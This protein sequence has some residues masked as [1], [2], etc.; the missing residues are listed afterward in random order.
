[1]PRNKLKGVV[2]QP[3]TYHHF[4]RG[5]NQIADVVRPTLGP[6]ARTVANASNYNRTELLDQGGVIA[7]R[8]IELPDG[9]EDMGAMYLRHLLWRLHEEQ[10]DGT[11]TAAVL[12]QSIYNQGVRYIA[13]GGNAMRLRTHLE[14][15]LR[16]VRET[17]Q[18][19]TVPVQ[20]QDAL[21]G[22]A[23]TISHDPELAGML[24]EI[25]DI[26]GEHG[27]LDIRNGRS[28]GLE[29]EYVEGS[30]WH[31]GIVSREMYAEQGKKSIEF[32][33]TAIF[34]SDLEFEEPE[35][36]APP[37]R[38]AMGAGKR[39][40][41]LLGSKFS[42]RVIGF[43]LTNSKP[44]KFRIL[45]VESPGLQA[46]DR[47]AAMQDMALLTG[48]TPFFKAT[49]Q[50]IAQVQPEHLGMARVAWANRFNVGV[51][52]GKGDPKQLRRHIRQLQQGF[53][54]A[55][56]P[57]IR[58]QLQK[59]L[60]KLMGGSATLRVGAVTKEEMDARKRLAET[61]ANALRGAV[62]TGIVPGGGV[63]FLHCAQALR[64]ALVHIPTDQDEKRAAYRILIQAMEQP[65]RVM[66]ENGGHD[67]GSVMA[68]IQTT[69][70][71]SG[72]DLRTDQ[73]V[74]VIEAGI[75]DVASVVDA[76]V[77]GAVS[78]AALA[79]TVDVLVHVK[80]PHRKLDT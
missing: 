7:R 14:D 29:R 11:A 18:A 46:D 37:V 72:F 19:L 53:T 20:G 77:S 67:P 52:G 21:A 38:A 56:N 80:V 55:N 34:I 9:N 40:L 10:G 30:Y 78:S 36:V 23:E 48:G 75:V 28:R 33:N 64:D 66:A 42:D 2:F 8:I 27:E 69:N 16:V 25:F 3:D 4:Q 43:M 51:R 79:L 45:A 58:Q 73:V 60:G 70:G 6:S 50:S 49:G 13:A 1:M 5:V 22:V 12:F 65:L 41:I 35:D 47:Q 59:R 26:I 44:E 57:D 15:G 32:Q 76:V 68:A 24:G 74:D 61:T 71:T 31:G 54:H 17:I 62:R 39:S 63:A